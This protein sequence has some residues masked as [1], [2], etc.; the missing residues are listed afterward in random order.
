MEWVRDLRYVPMEISDIKTTGKYT[1]FREGFL[2]VTFVGGYLNA[3][4][5]SDNTMFGHIVEKHGIR[6]H[7]NNSKRVEVSVLCCCMGV[8][9][10][11]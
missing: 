8:A 7:S 9:H 2:K 6:D 4:E 1:L 10:G 5:S 11:K 3:K